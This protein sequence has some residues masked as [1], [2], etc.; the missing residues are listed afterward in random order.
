MDLKETGSLIRKRREF[1]NLRQEDLA[2]LSKVGDKTIH[3]IEQGTGN[4]SFD[5]LGKVAEVLGLEIVV[6]IKEVN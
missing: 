4:P 6:K 3:L 2:E 1:L 5:T